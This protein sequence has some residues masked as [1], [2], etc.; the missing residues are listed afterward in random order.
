MFDSKTSKFFLPVVALFS[1]CC[2]KGLSF[3]DEIEEKNHI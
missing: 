2:F 1:Y 3:K